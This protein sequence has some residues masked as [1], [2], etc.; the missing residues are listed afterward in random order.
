MVTISEKVAAR[1]LK[2]DSADVEKIQRLSEHLSKSPDWGS[3]VELEKLLVKY[4]RS[5]RMAN[6]GIAQDAY[7]LANALGNLRE[8]IK[9]EIKDTLSE[10]DEMFDSVVF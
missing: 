4:A 10:I 7:A 6:P 3:L 9:V 2:A 5:I 8:H 1:F